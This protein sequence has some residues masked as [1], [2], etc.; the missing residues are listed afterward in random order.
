VLNVAARGHRPSRC[1]IF[2]TPMQ[3]FKMFKHE[4]EH[5]LSF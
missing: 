1:V 3:W 4:T 5:Y 2:P